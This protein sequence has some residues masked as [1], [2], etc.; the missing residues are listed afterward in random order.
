MEGSP[1]VL[2]ERCSEPFEAGAAIKR[3]CSERC[4][5]RAERSRRQARQR[6]AKPPKPPKPPYVRP[7]A[8]Q[9]AT[10]C[11]DCGTSDG[12]GWWLGRMKHPGSAGTRCHSCYKAHTRR[13]MSGDRAGTRPRHAIPVP[14]KVK[15]CQLLI[16]VDCGGLAPKAS[17]T[18]KRC[19]GCAATYDMKR[20]G[21]RTV[22]RLTVYRRGD[23][24]I[25][26]R[27][28]GERDGWRCHLCGKKV[29]AIA[30]NGVEMGGATV[31]HI[32]PLTLGGEHVW[33]NVALAHRS[34]NVSR[35]NRGSMQLRLVG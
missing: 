34:C 28:V 3:F 14:P 13:R 12:L 21:E 8:R 32:L 25:H 30:G 7:P 11:Q 26:W 22:H 9:V 1:M 31:D 20:R 35:G 27:T 10:Q 16:C 19:K 17:G 33:A 6:A 23:R 2:C 29:T 4:R 15:C 18:A 5:S 24:D